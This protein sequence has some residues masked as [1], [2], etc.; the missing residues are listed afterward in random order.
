[1]KVGVFVRIDEEIWLKFRKYCAEKHGKFHTV[2]GEEVGKALLEYL[3]STHT[4]LQQEECIDDM[5]R[6][7]GSKS[8]VV[9]DIPKIVQAIAE[10][11]DVGGK[12]PH[13]M[14]AGIITKA[15]GVSDGRSIKNRIGLLLAYGVLERDWETSEKGNVYIVKKTYISIGRPIYDSNNTRRL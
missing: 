9:K 7:V 13:N 8:R 14:L 10:V 5:H 4:H 3:E 11:C 12:I 2:L 15:T 1:M 6:G